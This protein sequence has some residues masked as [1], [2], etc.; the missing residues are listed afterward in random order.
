MPSFK[1]EVN[2]TI[3]TEVSPSNMRFLPSFLRRQY[4]LHHEK[5]RD[6][7]R[8]RFFEEGGHRL[9]YRVLIPDTRDYVDVVVDATVPI[10][11]AMKLSEPNT[12]RQ[13]LDNLYE[14]LFLM[15]QLFEEEIRK[16]T[17]Y[18]AFMPGESAS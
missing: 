4:L 16:S 18:L 12:Q 11:V 13:F 3:D 8:V 7:R 9:S 6:F 2:Y 10:R 5:Y 1:A 17:L 14:D 15:V